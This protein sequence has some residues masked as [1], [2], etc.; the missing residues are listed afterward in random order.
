M[1]QLNEALASRL[2]SKLGLLFGIRLLLLRAEHARAHPEAKTSDDHADQAAQRAAD[3]QDG[4]AHTANAIIAV[5]T[6]AL[7]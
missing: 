1:R 3:D 6:A 7:S 5:I 4:R 2:K